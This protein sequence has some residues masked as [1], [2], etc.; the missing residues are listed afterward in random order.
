M[1]IESGQEAATNADIL[2]GTRLA[3]APR[4]GIMTVS[5]QAADNDA[6]N[7]FTATLQTPDGDTPLNAARVPCG[8]TTGLAGVID[9]TTALQIQF[10]VQQGGQV[11]FSA[12]ETGDTELT[13]RVSF[14]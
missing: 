5:M 12:T 4:N 10:P 13:W 3:T 2:N 6:T 14:Q 9:D 8:N 11:L 1:L 7:N